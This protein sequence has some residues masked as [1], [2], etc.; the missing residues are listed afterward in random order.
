M[1]IDRLVFMA[2]QIAGYFA[3]YP[4]SEAV[5]GAANHIRMFWDPRMRR[6]IAA[7]VESGGA[8]LSPLARKALE[9]L[10][11]AA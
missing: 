1:D 5:A 7:H 10:R 4:E 9:S 8:G 11:Q 2:N 3:A 6:Q